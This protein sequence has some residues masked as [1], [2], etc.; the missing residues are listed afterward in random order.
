[1]FRTSQRSRA[2]RVAAGWLLISGLVLPIL[3]CA[4][5][6]A[7]PRVQEQAPSRSRQDVLTKIDLVSHDQCYT[8]P[9]THGTARC[10]R[11]LAQVRNIALSSTETTQNPP[12][13]TGAARA[14][15]QRVEQ[16]LGHD[17]LPPRP[18]TEQT[19]KNDLV[20]VDDALG[21]LRTALTIGPPG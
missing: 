15:E 14:L 5:Q 9:A 12:Q 8:S 16:L 17:C 4:G 6:E 21:D 10:D 1:M 7:G 2:A 20:A 11:Y 3:G 13:V 18:Q 19:C